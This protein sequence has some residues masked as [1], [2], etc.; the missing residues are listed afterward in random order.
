M[1][2]WFVTQPGIL[3]DLTSDMVSP[4]VHPAITIMALSETEATATEDLGLDNNP[5]GF[6]TWLDLSYIL[7]SSVDA[8]P[9]VL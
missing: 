5:I 7:I 3:D 2:S 1:A 9:L 6:H 8:F 4:L